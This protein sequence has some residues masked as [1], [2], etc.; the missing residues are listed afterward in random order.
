MV[1]FTSIAA[2]AAAIDLTDPPGINHADEGK[3]N[4]RTLEFYIVFSNG[5]G[6]AVW[7][8][9]RQELSCD[10]VNITRQ[11]MEIVE[12]GEGNNPMNPPD[13]DFVAAHEEEI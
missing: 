9:L 2:G 4:S 3:T 6:E 5:G 1:I 7:L 11:H 12:Q 13:D 10:G 8:R